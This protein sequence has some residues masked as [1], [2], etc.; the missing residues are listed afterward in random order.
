MGKFLFFCDRKFFC[1]F[2]FFEKLQAQRNHPLS[3][4]AKMGKKNHR[5]SA[6]WQ[7]PIS[8]IYSC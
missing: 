1:D 5:T 8:S 6:R 2:Y 3:K 7:I 4:L